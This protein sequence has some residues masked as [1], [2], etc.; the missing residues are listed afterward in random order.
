[1]PHQR[2]AVVQ[3]VEEPPDEFVRVL[4]LVQSTHG[5]VRACMPGRNGPERRSSVCVV[6]SSWMER[7]T[8][9]VACRACSKRMNSSPRTSAEA[10]L[11]A[12]ITRGRSLTDTRTIAQ[13]GG[14]PE[15]R[16]APGSPIAPRV[17]RPRA[18]WLSLPRPTTTWKTRRRVHS[19][20]SR[21]FH[22][23]GVSGTVTRTIFAS[24]H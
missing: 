16:H 17:A 23:R 1:M 2:H 9:Q 7:P 12:T 6:S 15:P 14:D 4:G 5:S 18:A 19:L 21:D 13:H 10:L 11:S 3:E 20:A 24:G 22:R 8:H